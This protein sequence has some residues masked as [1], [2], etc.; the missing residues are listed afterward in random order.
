MRATAKSRRTLGNCKRQ[1]SAA[2]AWPRTWC[3]HFFTEHGSLADED[4]IKVNLTGDQT[5][6]FT[7]TGHATANTQMKIVSA[8]DNIGVHVT[9]G[10][11]ASRNSNTVSFRFTPTDDGDYYVALSSPDH[12]CGA[13]QASRPGLHVQR[14]RE[15]T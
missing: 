1:E 2:W 6:L 9:D 7:L 4:W 14:G 5:Y 12:L 8:V 13:G 10:A 3:G 11:N 15:L